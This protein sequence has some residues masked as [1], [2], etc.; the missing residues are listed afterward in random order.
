MT[1]LR[2]YKIR[3]F[4]TNSL[5]FLP[6][7]GA[8]TAALFHR[9]VWTIDLRMHWSLLG[10]TPDGARA[11]VGAMS[12]SL[13]GF[14]VFLVT[15]IF[16]AVQLAVG[17]LTPRIIAVV[18][19]LRIVK[20]PLALFIF[21]YVYSL[22]ELGRIGEPVPQFAVMLTIIFTVTSI[23]VF[24][25]LIDALGRWLRPIKVFAAV[26]E[27]GMN[28]IEYVYPQFVEAK[29]ESS[30]TSKV[31]GKG[32]GLPREI[33]YRGK[34]GNFLAFDARGI[35]AAASR[36]GGLIKIVPQVGDF[37]VDGDPLLRISGGREDID[38]GDLR[39][40]VAV[41]PERTMEQDPAFAF[42]II[43]DITIKALSPSINDPT[44]AISGIDQIH[45]LLRKVG[46]R[47]MSDGRIYDESGQ[48]RLVFPVL[49]ASRSCGACGRCS[50]I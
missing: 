40:R 21:T 23:G 9:L 45:R 25:F 43:V 27:E 17:Q 41:G 47:D 42:R 16:V 5:W 38:E 31:P 19:R 29:P 10:F 34:A 36:A 2:R 22:G 28:C 49:A 15:M 11:M 39:Q 14:I 12:S 26:A 3:S 8:V 24:L 33:S 32:G 13:L 18:F 20:I 44:T 6:L 1:W 50:I 4:L 35:A 46:L 37:I 30:E 48:L 7:T